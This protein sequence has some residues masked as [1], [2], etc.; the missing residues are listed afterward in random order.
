MFFCT[1]IFTFMLTCVQTLFKRSSREIEQ[2]VKQNEAQTLNKLSNVNSRLK[3]RENL[4]RIL[5]LLC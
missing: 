1:N 5:F 2:Q 4:Y 3:K